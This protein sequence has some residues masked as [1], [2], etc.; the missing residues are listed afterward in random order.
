MKNPQTTCFL[1]L[2]LCDIVTYCAELKRENVE[3][4]LSQYFV[5]SQN[6]S[7][8]MFAFVKYI[9]PN[10]D[11]VSTQLIEYDSNYILSLKLAGMKCAEFDPKD[12]L[13]NCSLSMQK[14]N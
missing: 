9:T 2:S 8:Q 1:V 14:I 11:M 10:T 5:K 12:S 3:N 13:D 7:S 6:V 4:V